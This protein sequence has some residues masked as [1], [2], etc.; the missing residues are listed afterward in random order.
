MLRYLQI[1]GMLDAKYKKLYQELRRSKKKQGLGADRFDDDACAESL[2]IEFEQGSKLKE[3]TARKEFASA[4]LYG[5][6]FFVP[7]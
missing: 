4:Y 5:R 7:K 3:A 2:I 1:V 6:Y